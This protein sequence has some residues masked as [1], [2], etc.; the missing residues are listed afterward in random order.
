[1]HYIIQVMYIINIRPGSYAKETES[2]E[3]A[4]ERVDG[5]ERVLWSQVWERNLRWGMDAVETDS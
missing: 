4:S 3:E 1:M 5:G 2:G